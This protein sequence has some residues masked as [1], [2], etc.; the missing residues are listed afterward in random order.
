MTKETLLEK[1]LKK[2]RY[3]NKKT[4]MMSLDKNTQR[5]VAVCVVA[6][7]DGV[8]SGP[9]LYKILVD[10]GLIKKSIK[11]QNVYNYIATV[12]RQ[13]KELGLITIKVK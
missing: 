6:F 8:L 9:Q 11:K 1:A 3:T 4:V 5:E 12:I 2:P 10:I 13:C 7:L